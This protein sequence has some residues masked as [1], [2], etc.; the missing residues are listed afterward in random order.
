MFV[1]AAAD[2]AQ[3]ISYW[4]LGIL[5]ICVV[6]IVVSIVKFRI[7]PFLALILSAFLA[8]I[9]TGDLPNITPEN[10][11]LFHSRV[12]LDDTGIE[13]NNLTKS[14]SWSLMGFGNTAG[15]IGLVVALAAII[16]T[17]MMGSGAADRVVRALLNTFGEKRA[18]IVLLLS[19][20]LLSI[21]VFF[22]TVF[23]PS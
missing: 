19:G 12:A 5:A 22:D 23:F 21:P 3:S 11:G 9:L 14:I 17:C 8:G 20:F 6:F 7:H 10:K 18:G 4:P 13:G 1:L 16:G 15:G 2:T